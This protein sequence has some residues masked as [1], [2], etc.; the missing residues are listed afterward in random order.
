[1]WWT[2]NETV[3]PALN[4]RQNKNSN[5]WFLVI[6]FHDRTLYSTLWTFCFHSL[7]MKKKK[8]TSYFTLIRLKPSDPTMSLTSSSVK[9]V[10]D[11]GPAPPS[12]HSTNDQDL[13]VLPILLFTPRGK[14]LVLENTV[15][16]IS[17]PGLRVVGQCGREVGV[18]SR[19]TAM[20]RFP[21]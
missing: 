3:F 4:T 1:M 7:I 2:K 15:P 18:S 13:Q 16:S 21:E 9:R 8:K 14:S 19:V 17:D 10:T 20:K 12:S 6:V 11:N 5:T